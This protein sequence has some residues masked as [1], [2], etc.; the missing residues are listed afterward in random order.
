MGVFTDIVNVIVNVN[1]EKSGKTLKELKKDSRQLKRELD[2]LVPGTEEFIKK[3]EELKRVEAQLR[4]VQNEIRGVGGAFSKIKDEIRQFG[5]LAM[6]YMGFEFITDSVKNIIS[7]NAKLSD[8]IADIQKSTGMS[9]QEAEKLNQSLS[10]IDTRTATSELR[11]IAAAGGQIG[12]AAKDIE[13][14]TG[15]TDKLVVSLGDEFAGGAEEVTKA[16]GGLRNVFTDIKSDEIDKDMLRIGNA[17]NELGAAGFATG[18]VM[19]DMGSRIGGVVIPL[20]VATDKVLGLSATMQELN[21]SAEVGGTAVG[22]IFQR[23]TTHTAEFARVAG[24]VTE[25]EIKDFTQLVNTDLYGAFV[26]VI[27]GAKDSG[28]SATLLGKILEGLGLSGSGASQV[29]L[30]LGNN[31]QMLEEKVKLS[32]KALQETDSIMNEFNTKNQTFGA[33][34]DK[35]GKKMNDYFSNSAMADG[36][37]SVALWMDEITETPLSEKLEEDQL[38]LGM[39]QVKLNDVNTSSEDRIALIQEL[40]NQYP[41]YLGNLNAEK[42]TNEQLNHAIELVN[43]Q[44]I[45]KIILQKKEEEVKAAANDAADIALEKIEYERKLTEYIT[46]AK[47]EHGYVL[48]ENVSIQEQASSAVAFLTEKTKAYN[49][50]LSKMRLVTSQNEERHDELSKGLRS[51]AKLREGLTLNMKNQTWATRDLNTATASYNNIADETNALAIELGL[52]VKKVSAANEEAKRTSAEYKKGNEDSNEELKKQIDLLK[53]L[54]AQI[55]SAEEAFRISQLEGK[56]KDIAEIN[57]KYDKL[58]ASAKGH[59]AEL[60]R[61]EALRVAEILAVNKKYADLDAKN[62]QER[63]RKREELSEQ[64]YG[65]LL[66]DRDR[67][68]YEATQRHQLK[69]EELAAAGLDASVLYEQQQAEILAIIQ[70]W[71]KKEVDANEKKNADIRASDQQALNDKLASIDAQA[72]VASSLASAFTS[73]FD[74]LGNESADYVRFQKRLALIQIGVDTAAAIAK[75]VVMSSSNPANAVTGGLAGIAQYASGFALIMGNIAKARAIWEESGEVPEYRFGGILPGPSHEQG[76][77]GVYNGRRKV[78][79]IEGYEAMIPAD[80]TAA[81]PGIINALLSA[82]GRSI[83]ALT[84]VPAPVSYSTAAKAVRFGREQSTGTPEFAQG[85]ST[86]GRSSA[87]GDELLKAVT[88]LNQLLGNGIQAKLVYDS[89]SRDLD[90]ISMAKSSAVIGSRKG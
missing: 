33:I 3:M 24:A 17:L 69:N 35:L 88:L 47:L 34:V 52:N 75:L 16:L 6:S 4:R 66:S 72:S 55:L 68:L 79:E 9:Q 60:K 2:N 78:A 57:L 25:N 56:E 10:K 45:N 43:N 71:N 44:L 21:I 32:G 15:A 19:A 22:K 90:S 67:E 77:L 30:K 61:I 63:I 84:S 54:R 14:F 64:V 7:K 41:E 53:N 49:D 86:S 58:A 70:K 29:F 13:K 73:M 83:T 12:V 36:L 51:M 65:M 27:T 37:K 11:K 89:Y 38:Q 8:E 76:G 85:V 40:Q 20:G 82:R 23:M 87:S 80:T 42:A 1:G 74:A 28:T 46:K 50:E 31:T 5:I 62:E 18:P 39:L 48:K 26:K 81:N 59:S